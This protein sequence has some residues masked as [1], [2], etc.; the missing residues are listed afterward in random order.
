MICTQQNTHLYQNKVHKERSLLTG[1][2]P[3]FT[4]ANFSNP[5]LLRYPARS[6][7]SVSERKP[8]TPADPRPSLRL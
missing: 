4:G 8:L 6:T 2:S 3:L 1:R 7:G 5:H